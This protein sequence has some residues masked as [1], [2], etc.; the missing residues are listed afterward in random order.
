[1]GPMMG[2]DVILRSKS[3][4]FMHFQLSIIV[5]GNSSSHFLEMTLLII[6]VGTLVQNRDRKRHIPNYR[7]Q[8]GLICLPN[9]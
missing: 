6:K 5:L 4:F 7:A 1:M 9:D 8:M 3:R 2:H